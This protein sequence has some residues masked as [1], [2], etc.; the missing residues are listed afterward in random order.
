MALGGIG[1]LL[2]MALWVAVPA[3]DE[4]ASIGGRVV[5]DRRE[6]QIVLAFSTAV[7]A[8][9]LVLQAVGLNGLGVP[10]WTLLAAA[11]RRA[12]S[13]GGA[14]RRRSRPGCASRSTPHR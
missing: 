3:A 9:L 13:C 7:L 8:V 2:Y 14:P 4:D 11:R 12:S 6:L 10:A 5:G 1:I